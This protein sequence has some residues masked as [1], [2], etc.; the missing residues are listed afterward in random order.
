M[1]LHAAVLAELLAA[2]PPDLPRVVH[3]AVEAG[4]DAAVVAHAPLAAQDAY[5]AGAHAQEIRLY[6]EI[7]R[8]RALLAPAAEAQILQACATARFTT[9]RIGEALEASTA[10]VRIRE[11]LGD[12]AELAAALAGLAPI[13]WALSGRTTR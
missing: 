9:D 2:D 11:K 7:L 4:D 5:R 3:H 1:A 13:Q 10:A 12:P 6:E 8:R